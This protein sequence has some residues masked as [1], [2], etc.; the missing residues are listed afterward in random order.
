MVD[1]INPK[2]LGIK[3]CWVNRDKKMWIDSERP[4]YIIESLDDLYDLL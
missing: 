4:D 1:N 2:K 3:T